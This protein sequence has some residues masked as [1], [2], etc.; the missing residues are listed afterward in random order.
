MNNKLLQEL[1]GLLC[2]TFVADNALFIHS[3]EVEY[4]ITADHTGIG[5]HYY[6]L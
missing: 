6:C 4:F 3:V 1:N 5:T 2:F